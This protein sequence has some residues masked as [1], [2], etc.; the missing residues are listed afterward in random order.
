M[1]AGHGLAPITGSSGSVGVV[2]YLL[3][4][5]LGPLARSH[6]A[7]SD[8]VRGLRVVL[9]D[10]S[11]VETTAEHEPDLFWAL[12]G[13]KGGLG[14]VT[15]VDVELVPLRTLYGGSLTVDGADAADVLRA[16]TRWTT[17]APDDVTTSVVIL[18]LPDLPFVPEPLR[19]RTVLNLR[20]AYPGD[21]AEGERLAAP[22]RAV[23]PAL[24]D[25]I[26]EMPAAAI[27]TI[28]ADPDD[29][30]PSWVAGAE[31]R[32]ID[33]AFVDRYLGAYG[34]GGDSP[35]LGAEIRHLGGAVARDV[36]GG[37]AV[38]GR[39]GDYLLAFVGMN[40]PLVPAMVA[41]FADFTAWSAPWA[42]SETNVNFLPAPWTEEMLARAWSPQTLARLREVRSQY[43][44][45]GRF[46][47]GA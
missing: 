36:P 14:I 31:L 7:S 11:V 26:G 10:G 27:A 37:S 4:G 28:H 6:G 16:W 46:P 19:G 20:F 35:F 2:G 24:V 5:G 15:R 33:D 1:A 41:S 3:G 38:G 18:S 25:T 39:T 17:T 47:F 8:R 32:T 22:L 40:P 34:P 21:A 12:R 23:A 45:D 9:A 13:G 29:P 42:A 44:P 43:D 30:G